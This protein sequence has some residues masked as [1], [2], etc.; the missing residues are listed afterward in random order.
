MGQ[1]GD[2]AVGDGAVG[3][4]AVG[5]RE[6]AEYL[7]LALTWGLSFLALVRAVDGF[8]W[9]A[10]V[11]LRSLLAGGLLFGVALLMGRRLT[12]GAQWWPFVVVGA[13]TV[14]GQSIGLSYGTPLIGTAMAAIF[15]TTIPLFSMVISS[16]WGLERLGVA[17][18]GGLLLGLAGMV[19]LVGFPAETVTASFVAGCAA[20]LFSTF[21]AAFGSNY[22]S[23]WLRGVG[24]WEV[25]IASF[26]AGGVMTLPL[27][28]WVPLPRVPDALDWLSLLILAGVVSGLNYV[29][30]FRLVGVIGATRTISVEFVVTVIAVLVGA[31]LLG[32]RLTGVQLLGAGVIVLGCALV[33]GLLPAW[34]RASAVAT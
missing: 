24:S 30:Y 26:L 14:A 34:R 20:M 7:F 27:M 15:V 23:R 25:T 29:I 11:S 18:V 5:G 16:L 4:G 12:F 32:E 22:A 8:G 2:G 17:Q 19:L 3:A 28:L 10:S 33:L 1:A 31:L 9:A 6:V 21:C 13:T